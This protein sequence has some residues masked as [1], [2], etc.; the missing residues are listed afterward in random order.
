MVALFVFLMLALNVRRAEWIPASRVMPVYVGLNVA[1]TIAVI[2]MNALGL[3]FQLLIVLAAL[4]IIGTEALIAFRGK[5]RPAT[6]RYLVLGFVFIV[7][8]AS[9]SASDVSRA[10]CDPKNHWVQGHAI[11]HWIGAV[12]VGFMARHYT[13]LGLD[14]RA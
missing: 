2:A 1:A 11:W 10:W 7:I 13:A 9:F 6:Y 12:A 14:E 4:S 3:H 8:A 5:A